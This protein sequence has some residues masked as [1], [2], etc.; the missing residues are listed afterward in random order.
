[1]Q[2]NQENFSPTPQDQIC[3]THFLIEDIEP[4][5][6]GRYPVLKPDAVPTVFPEQKGD[7]EP[8]KCTKPAIIKSETKPVAIKSQTLS[9][10]ETVLIPD[11]PNASGIP[12]RPK[13]IILQAKPAINPQKVVQLSNQP[14]IQGTPIISAPIQIQSRGVQ[15]QS[16]PIQIQPKPIQIQKIQFHPNIQLQGKPQIIQF[17]GKQFQI[18]QSPIPIQPKSPIQIQQSPIPIQQKSPI[19]IAQNTP[20]HIP[21]NSTIRIQ[22]AVQPNGKLI[23]LKQINE[24]EL[25]ELLANSNKEVAN[26][27][28]GMK[29][30][31]LKSN[32]LGKKIVNAN[33]SLTSSSPGNKK[34]ILK[35]Q[36]NKL[37]DEGTR[38]QGA[39]RKENATK[40]IRT[41]PEEV[42][43]KALNKSVIFRLEPSGQIVVETVETKDG[44]QKIVQKVEP[45]IINR[46]VVQKPEEVKQ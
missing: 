36:I 32:V 22:Q 33:K 21:S 23:S 15:I 43:I 20:I 11:F 29:T 18:Q 40:V 17:Q 25:K 27:E 8:T 10:F 34:P 3:S 45:Q 44:G 35:I 42:Q 12:I 31:A 37:N 39:T 24:A 28:I 7:P 46:T 4:S 26:K 16:K 5:S 19:Q 2:I 30:S 41:K 6:I 9:H 38:K 1:M 13:P 14:G